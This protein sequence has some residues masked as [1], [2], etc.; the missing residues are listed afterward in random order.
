MTR[1]REAFIFL[2]TLPQHLMCTPSDAVSHFGFYFS[3]RNPLIDRDVRTCCMTSYCS[4]ACNMC[5]RIIQII[6]ANNTELRHN[7]NSRK[8]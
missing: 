8:S 5:K 3:K 6:V 2:A 7:L 4:R 1:K